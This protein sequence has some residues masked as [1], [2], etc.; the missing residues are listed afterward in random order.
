METPSPREPAAQTGERRKD[1]GLRMR[2]AGLAVLVAT[3]AC[4]LLL[5]RHPFGGDFMVGLMEV[6][7][8][9]S[10]GLWGVIIAVGLYCL[11]LWASRSKPP[12][13]DPPPGNG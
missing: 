10:C 4:L 8:A 1:P 11:G 2:I 6:F 5:S 13:P 3:A 12:K 9:A 7:V